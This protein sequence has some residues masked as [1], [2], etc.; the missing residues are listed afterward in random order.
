MARSPKKSPAPNGFEEAPQSSFEGA[1]LSGSVADW[2][3]QLEADA[4]TSG[5]ETQRQIASKA[6]KHRKKVEIAARTKT[7]D[8]GVSASK[9][10]RG[11]S[12]GGSTDPKTRAAA[13][14]NPVSG[15]DTTLEEASSLQAGTAVTA[16]VEALSALIE[17]G[18]PLHKNG[19][20]WT[21]HRP[22]RPDKSEG[23][24]AI[25]MQSDYE[26][27]GDQ[28]TAIRDLVEGLENGDRSQVLLGVTGSGKTFTMAKVIEATQRPAVILAP[29]KTLAAQL[30]SEFK[31][32][33]PD[34][35][36]EYFVSY[37][38]YYQPE[39]YVPRSDTYI[40][41]ESSINEQID[42]MRHSATRSLLE[43]DDCI[44][45]ASVSCIYGI[46]SVETYTA[47]T[48]QMSVGDRLDQRQLLADLVAQQY[49]RRDMDFTR[50][51]FR[52]R[53]DT[54]EL[55]PAHLEDA[56]WRISMFGDEIDAITE[57][58]PLTGQKVGD[59]KSVKIYA[60]SH[61]V[62]PR[63]T[64]NGAIKSIKEELRLRLAEL[65]K[66]GRLLEAQRL[67]QRTRYD[68]EMLEATGSCQGIENYSRYLTGRDPGDPP[69]TLFEYI[70]D[71]A[72]VF[73]D[74][75]H[76]TVP[77]IGGM[78]RGDFRR[79]A[80][81]AEYGFRLPSCMDNRPLRFEEWDAMRPDTIAVSATPGSW[82]MEQS[83]GVFAEQV[84]RPTGLIDPPVEVRSARTQV[85]DVLGEIRETAAKG[86][87][88][89]CTV[90]TKRM[91]E[92]LTEYLH[93][94][95]VRVRYMHSDIDTLERIEILRDL[96]LGAFDVLVGINLLREGLDIPECGFVAILDADKEGFLRSE[97]SL[98]QTIG[99][100]A[101]N[102]DG[103]VILYA[104]QVTGSMKRAMEETG[105]RREKQMI[106]NQEHGITPESVKAR[107][108]DILDSVY[109]RDHVRADISGVSGKGFADGG[110]LV[111]NNLQTHL[112]A[113]EKSMRD[114]AA[115]LDFEKAA[116]LRDE[117]KRLKAAE[118]A[119]MDDPM[120][121]EEARH[122]E[123]GKRSGRANR[124]SLPPAGEKVPG[125]ADEGATPSYFSRPSLDDMGP[126]TDT[127]TP[128]FRKPALDEM[129]RDIAEPTKKTLF[130]KNDL[131]EMTVG[132]TEKPVTGALPEKP[133]GEARYAKRSN[134]SS[135]SI[136][137]TNAR[138]A[139]EGQKGTKR[140]SPLLEGQPE[141]DDVRP[142]VRGKTG[143]G[144]YEDP[145]EQ[146]R[147]G[148]TKGKTGRPGK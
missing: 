13:G 138:S 131:D 15:M 111:G 81:L 82:E 38:D 68:I 76:V 9:S 6:G 137:A 50:G 107:I 115:D 20:I 67:E 5:V 88:T 145:G 86:Y 12:M 90:L 28:P 103:K 92:D 98:I 91:A 17:S 72:L 136:A 4:E 83:G 48:F 100:A 14:L 109:E 142:V 117:I 29:N 106:Y 121:R 113:L 122:Q 139:S 114:A 126:G 62:T 79:K 49:K 143:V 89:L 105:R 25:R 41:K 23:G 135:E 43:R 37:Y 132:R 96:R 53:G 148:R 60:N 73:I 127:T 63:P 1:P 42:R 128:L 118:L 52:V 147:K 120:A 75:S 84:I 74:E 7:G 3:K 39:A 69:P 24:I 130:R 99:R 129:G 55:F 125:R 140:F 46:G 110:N 85:D 124:E 18:N 51:S 112:N 47:M 21:P 101:R 71:N 54:I 66:A 10:A 123:G 141:R 61:Y 77:Q 95:G 40:E 56:A 36:V 8:G 59:L 44:I 26:P 34:N 19:K 104:D 146:K 31:N 45:V 16:T 134:R 32:F 65:E 133:D 94:Q 58:D 35:A 87:R 70:P 57:F 144:S 119:V 22:A 78:Y 93:E 2:V 108:S 116:R 27:A 64:L 80:T 102:V 11:T 97:T 33:F 30:Y